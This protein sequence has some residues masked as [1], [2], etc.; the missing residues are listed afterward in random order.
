MQVCTSLQTANY[1]STPA[2]SYLQAGC[3][4]CRPTNS[5]RALK[6][7]ALKNKIKESSRLPA[8][9]SVRQNS[10]FSVGHIG[11][12][13]TVIKTATVSADCRR[14]PPTTWLMVRVIRRNIRS[15]FTPSPGL[16]RSR[17]TQVPCLDAVAAGEIRSYVLL[18][19][20]NDSKTRTVPFNKHT[21]TQIHP[22]TDTKR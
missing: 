11:L 6:A 10:S 9:Q 4:S 12:P 7:K 2:L 14:R 16:R 18:R 13:S 20:H 21:Y 22:L 3:P 8:S 5:V 19:C 1:A 15:L 17:S